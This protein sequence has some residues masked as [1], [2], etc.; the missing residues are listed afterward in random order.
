MRVLVVDDELVSR[1]KMELIMRTFGECVAV[2]NGE[3]ALKAFGDAIAKGEPF[4]LITLD[5]SM[6]DM[7]GT[8]V[9]YEI[10]KIEKKR[11]IPRG[12]WLKV[13]MVTAQSD[14][15]TVTLCIQVGCDSYITKPFDRAIIAKKL[16]E[17]GMNVEK[18]ARKNIR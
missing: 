14:K 17:L 2:D 9:L 16:V 13:I 12:S 1:K 4:D 11:K 18:P 15:E 10:R 7:D 5:V 8:E 6:P 3:A